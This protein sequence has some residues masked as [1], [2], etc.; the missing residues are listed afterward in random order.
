MRP[1]TAVPPTEIDFPEYVRR[2][3]AA[4][5]EVGCE[6]EIAGDRIR[7]RPEDEATVRQAQRITLDSM[8][9]PYEMVDA[10]HP[11]P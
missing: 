8:G 10:S 2:V 11:R 3:S 4:L 1:A 9:I 6:V 5:A 7:F